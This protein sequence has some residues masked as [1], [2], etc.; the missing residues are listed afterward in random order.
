[1]IP[2]TSDPSGAPATPRADE[3]PQDKPLPKIDLSKPIE[4]ASSGTGS[5]N[6]TSGTDKPPQVDPPVD[7]SALL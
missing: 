4:V 1:M 3:A 7:F 2:N 6:D 5:T